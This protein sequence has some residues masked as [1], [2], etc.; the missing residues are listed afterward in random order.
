MVLMFLL[1]MMVVRVRV[2][3]LCRMDE[4]VGKILIEF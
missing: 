4:K 1:L 3:L 2:M